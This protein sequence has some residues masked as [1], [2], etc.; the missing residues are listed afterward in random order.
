MINFKKIWIYIKRYWWAPVVLIAAIGI[1]VLSAGRSGRQIW[2]LLENTREAAQKEIEAI[3]E[4]EKKKVEEL[5]KARKEY[6]EQIEDINSTAEKK[7]K[8]LKKE[9]KKQ[10]KKDI[11][12]NNEDATE[13]A[14]GLQ[15]L[16]DD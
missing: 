9:K 14:R 8:K 2:R 12:D 11:E 1:W 4:A 10:I 3:E 5:S 7:E 6:V 13:L 15:D 16:L